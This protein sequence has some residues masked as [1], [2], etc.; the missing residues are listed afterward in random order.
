MAITFLDG[1]SLGLGFFIQVLQAGRPIARIFHTAGV[2]RFYP[3]DEPTLGAATL[4]SQDLDRIKD[5]IRERYRPG[6]S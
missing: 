5:T 1:S 4:Q 3:G 2:Y 6:G